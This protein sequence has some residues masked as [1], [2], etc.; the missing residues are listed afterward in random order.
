M[1]DPFI[2]FPSSLSPQED[3]WQRYNQPRL[4]FF[5]WLLDHHHRIRANISRRVAQLSVR[6][7]IPLGD[8]FVSFRLFSYAKPCDINGRL[9]VFS[10]DPL[11][12]GSLSPVLTSSGLAPSVVFN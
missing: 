11:Y 8:P 5:I 3:H 10:S 9:L 1:A 4:I 12:I 2:I 7:R 6:T